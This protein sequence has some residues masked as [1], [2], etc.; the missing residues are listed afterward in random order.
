MNVGAVLADSGDLL[1]EGRGGDEVGSRVDDTEHSALAVTTNGAVEVSGPGVGNDLAED[2]VL[3]LRARSEGTLFSPVARQELGGL[4]DGVVVGPPSELD[5]LTDGG[6]HGEG[7]VTEDTLG[8]SDNDG[9]GDASSDDD[10]ATSSGGWPVLTG[11]A[12]VGSNALLDTVIVLVMNTPILLAGP[13]GGKENGGKVDGGVHDRGKVDRL[14]YDRGDV[15]G[16]V[17]D[18]WGNVDGCVHR[19]EMHRSVDENGGCMN[20]GGRMDGDRGQHRG[21]EQDDVRLLDGTIATDHDWGR[22]GG[23]AS[24]PGKLRGKLNGVREGD[25]LGGRDGN[26]DANS[27]VFLGTGE[28]S[29]ERREEGDSTDKRC[30]LNHFERKGVERL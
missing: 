29:C 17:H 28:T 6:V 19:G 2:E 10:G 22:G 16:G 20:G 14:V 3:D 9:V 12:A 25:A 24:F 7:N 26:L 23:D 18:R 5:G 1:V 8:G 30:D 21:R 13:V 27:A 11:A 15:N 4:G